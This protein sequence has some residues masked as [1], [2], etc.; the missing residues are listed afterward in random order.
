MVQ[1][2]FAEWFYFIWIACYAITYCIVLYKDNDLDKAIGYMLVC[3]FFWPLLWA[4]FFYDLF[5]DK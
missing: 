3:G 5:N 2:G 1:W 4:R